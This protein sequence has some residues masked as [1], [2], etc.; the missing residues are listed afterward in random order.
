MHDPLRGYSCVAKDYLAVSTQD[1]LYS[2]IGTFMM[3][4]LKL[5]G[6]VNK[7]FNFKKDV[8]VSPSNYKQ[9]NYHNELLYK[10]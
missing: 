8:V 7:I 2:F 6:S 5:L 4:W 3:I 9:R 10:F 1:Q